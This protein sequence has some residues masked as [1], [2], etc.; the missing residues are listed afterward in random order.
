MFT[1]AEVIT[2]LTRIFVRQAKRFPKGIEGV[3]IRLKAKKIYD[4]AKANNYQGKISEDQLK[5]FLAWEKQV[6][7]I[8]QRKVSKDLFKVPE[9][10]GEVIKVDFDPSGKQTFKG[11]SEGVEDVSFK[12]GMDPKGKIVVESPSQIIA[13]MKKMTPIEAMKEA[14]SVIGRKGKYKNLT[15]DESQDIL[16]KTDDHIFE[17]D[18]KYDEFGDIIKPDPEDLAHGGRTGTGL[19]YLMGEDDQN[20]RV[21]YQWGGPGGKSPGTRA[22][23]RPGQ[24]HRETHGAPPGI[25]TTP[26]H[27]PASTKK[28][29]VSELSKVGVQPY[30]PEPLWIPESEKKIKKI[31][32]PHIIDT[33]KKQ[34]DY[35]FNK[36]MWE[37]LAK[38]KT[39]PGRDDFRRFP[40]ERGETQFTS[41]TLLDKFLT[42]ISLEYPNMKITNEFG[43]VDKDKAKQVID[44]AY[45][46]GKISLGKYINI[47]RTLDTTGEGITGID[48]GSDLFNVSGSP[49]SDEY[50]VGSKFNIGDLDLGFTGDIQEGNITKKGAT[51]DYGDGTLKGGFTKDYVDDSTLSELGYDKTFD[52]NDVL[53]ANIKADISKQSDQDFTKSSLIPSLDV[54]LPVG[55]GTLKSNISKNI[56]EGGETNL[57]ASLSYP[58]LGGEFKAGASDILSENPNALLGYS[59][60]KGDPYSTD[61]YLGFDVNWDPIKGDKSAFFGFK[62]KF[63]GGGIAGMLGEPTYADGGRVPLGGGKFVF[64]AAR[65]KFLQMVG[66]G[67]AG[68]TAAK[69]GLFGLLKGGGKKTVIKDLTSVPIKNIKDMPAWF[70]PLVNQIIRKGNQV[71]SGTERVIVHKSKLPNSKTDLYVTQELD[72]GNVMVDIGTGKHGF[73]AGHHGQPVRLEYRASEEILLKGKKGSVKTKPEFNV[74]EAE[75]TGGHPE[76]VKFEETSIEKFGQHGSDFSEVEKFATGKVKSTKPTKKRSQTEYE[77]DKA[78]ADAERWTEEADDFSSGGRVPL[79]GGGGSDKLEETIRA[80]RKYQGSRKNPRLNFQRFFEIYAKENF[81]TGGRVP[82]AGGKE[83]LKGLA[84]LANK[85][86]PKSTKIGK[87]SKTMA[88]KTQL[89]QAISGFQE[90]RKVAELKEMIR[91]KYEGVVD[92]RLLNQMLVDDNPQRI[93]EVM[94]TIDEA[95]IMQGKGMGHET[96]MQSFKDSWKRKPQASGGLAGMLGE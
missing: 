12:P 26:T 9:K 56:I 57:G 33:E 10:K 51:F 46:D 15:I 93:A 91:K 1:I 89:K 24:G 42:N 3:D 74:E 27:R 29:D 53:K 50:T 61:P 5:Q 38:Y 82:L 60:N 67:A 4:V 6:K 21:P 71:E 69:T 19:N 92:E 20:M 87:T 79:S 78:Q 83:V 47:S 36:K 28:L 43:Y 75:W 85:I 90:R 25:T 77:S 59:Y 23:Y 2:L 14:N 70:Q 13:R 65:R 30:I 58:L 22:D 7:P 18:I 96:I 86:A 34:K 95:L 44:K 72:T 52:L 8:I 68:V 81:A 88:E 35:F 45:F 37:N 80:Y 54:T 39:L 16:K 31:I 32:D 55:S 17:R 63:A 66:A 76:N 48:V 84:W 41:K 49:D 62:K 40:P 11:I 73:S 94:A 64:D